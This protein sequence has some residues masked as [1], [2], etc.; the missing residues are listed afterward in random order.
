MGS[1]KPWQDVMEVFTG[2]TK[3]DAQ[4]LL[5]Y[6]EPLS[7]WLEERNAEA[8][9]RVGWEESCPGYGRAGFLANSATLIYSLA[10]ITILCMRVS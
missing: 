3:M 1:S 10:F 9:D 5:E 2:Q 8:G 7:M 6:F 4:P